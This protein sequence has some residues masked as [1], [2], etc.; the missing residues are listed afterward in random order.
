MSRFKQMKVG[1]VGLIQQLDDGRIIQL[2][3]TDTQSRVLQAFLASLS[4][5]APL[6]RMGSDYELEFK[7]K[8]SE[9]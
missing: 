2:G 8:T 9:D 4:K 7:N 1:D 6:V 5:D 3:L